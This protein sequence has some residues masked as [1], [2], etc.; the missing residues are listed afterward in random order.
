MLHTLN[1]CHRFYAFFDYIGRVPRPCP[2]AFFFPKDYPT[3]VVW[4]YFEQVDA[5][6]DR[7]ITGPEV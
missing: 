7:Y 3:F 4:E 2:Q 1:T 6:P 5:N